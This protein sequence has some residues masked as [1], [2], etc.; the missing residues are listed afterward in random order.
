MPHASTDHASALKPTHRILM[1]RLVVAVL[2]AGLLSSTS[3]HAGT[4]TGAV[5]LAAGLVLVGIC[6]VGRLWCALY[7]S[8]YK[9]AGLV[10]A[11]PYSLC[12]HPLYFCSVLGFIGIG[13]ATQSL[14]LAAGAAAGVLLGYPSVLRREDAF[15]RDRFGDSWDAYRARTPALAPRLANWTEPESYTVHPR[16]FGRAARDVVWFVWAVALVVLVRG[17]Q[18]GVQ[19]PVALW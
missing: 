17:L 5:L 6:V 7:I 14:T 16:Q 2:A 8:G 18:Q 4:A 12:R 9:D 3:V 10:T 15:L 1:S 11:G 13:L 19:L